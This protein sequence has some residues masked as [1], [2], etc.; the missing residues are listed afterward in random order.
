MKKLYFFL[1]F[2][3][4]IKIATGQVL[5]EDFSYTA[6]QL[7]TANGWAAYSGAGTN[8]ITVTSPGLTYTGHPGSGVG[9]A[10]TM[11]TSGEDDSKSFTAIN[12]GSVYFSFLTNVSAAQATGD[13]FIGLF[14]TS[15]I[16]PVRIYAKPDGATGFFFGVS[17]GNS[18]AVY[19]TTSRSF[20]TTYFIISNYI[21]NAATTTDDVIN[22]WVNPALG[23]SETA[24]TIPNVTGTSTDATTI[25]A[26]YLRQGAATTASTQKVDAILAGTTWAEVTPAAAA[27]PSLLAGTLTGFGNVTVATN[28]TS[29]SFTLSGTNLTGAPG[30]ITVTAP[31]TDFQVSNNNS[32]WGSSTTIPYASATLSSTN[33]YARFTPQSAGL[34]TG[35]ISISGGGATASVAVSGTGTAAGGPPAAPVAIAATG[36]IATGFTANWNAVSGA[37]NYFLDVY[38]LTTGTVTDTVAGWNFGVGNA[39]NQ[40]ADEGN[41]NNLGI[42]TVTPNGVGT[43]SWPGGPGAPNSF[44]VS[45]TGWDNGADTK[46][47]SVDVNTTGASN[48]T[49]SSLQGA[50]NTGPKDFKLQYKV[51]AAGTWTD[52]AGG[53]VTLTTA[54]AAGNPATWGTLTNVALPA[55]ANNQAL[56]SVRWISTSNTSVNGATVAAGG[57]SRISAIYIKGDVGGGSTPLYVP[58]YQNLSVGN[59]TSHNVTGLTNN[60]TY[61]YVVRANNASG[62]SANSNE[63]TVT[64]GASAT[65]TINATSLAVFGNVCTGNTGGPNSFTINGTNLT[66]AN[67]AVG[68]LA[69]YTFSTTSGGVYTNSLSL[70][71]PGGSYSQQVFVKFSPVAIQSYNGNIPVSGGGIAAI[72][73]VVA[74]GAGVNTSTSVTSGAATAITFNSATVAGSLPSTGCTPITSYGIAYSTTSGFVTGTQV[75]STNLA[76]G[77][78]TSSLT[79]LVAS[80]TYYYKAYA[81]DGSG[82]TYGT[83]LSFTTIAPPSTLTASALTGFGN[84]CAGTTAGPN[85]FTLTGSALTTADV[86]VGPLAGYSF[87]TTA[88]GTY[89]A[90]LTITQ[91]G[92]AFNQTVYV[93]FTPVITQTYNGNIPVSGGGATALNVAVTGSGINTP[94][95]VTTNAPNDISINA[96]NLVGTVGA[97]GCSAT[98]DYGFEYSTINGFANGSGTQVSV[99]TSIGNALYSTRL[100]GLLQGVT[101]Y[102]KAYAKNSGGI[103][104]GAQQSFTVVSIPNGFTIYPVP[105]QRGSSIRVTMNNLT[106]GYY[107]LLLYN[108]AG[109]LVYQKN[110]NIQAN[111]INQEIILP[112]TMARGSY[113]L[114]LVNHEKKIATKAIVVL[115]H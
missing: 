105:V 99:G 97:N 54:V 49:V 42:Q 43:V 37:T 17:K 107:G 60:T 81:I 46:Y 82:T 75:A 91:P 94:P 33:V 109:E 35:N 47:W 15:S 114:Q 96:A 68:P 5:T 40:T 67:I 23:G 72:V 112:A 2:F 51:G 104:Y 65:P 56:I 6:G 12:S 39:S 63:I 76:G 52:V 30:N 110:I 95:T 86:T 73:N 38:T 84:I 77:N 115:G 80:T 13:Y 34:K 7:I 11:T 90:S 41:A 36:I 70:T 71:Q 10:V 9:N 59:V 24:A 50:S 98:T 103:S 88:G 61:Y 4:A 18:T 111:F 62:T 44:S 113:R 14:Q 22:L 87:S 53:V 58:G 93:K 28:S 108:N 78:F 25:A 26:V 102:Y 48:I 101:Y 21:Y 27:T 83:Q 16:F 64:T 32:T 8:A 55:N 92:G 106:P 89:T 29:Q 19:E 66:N 31:S 74:S 45:A 85:S 20:G 100:N 3:L 57:T 79:G 1:G 69:G